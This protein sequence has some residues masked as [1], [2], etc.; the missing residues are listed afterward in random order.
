M[1]S[2]TRVSGHAACVKDSRKQIYL[3]LGL[4][5]RMNFGYVEGQ[6]ENT[7]NQGEKTTWY[8][9]K[10]SF[11]LALCKKLPKLCSTWFYLGHS[12]KRYT[13]PEDCKSPIVSSFSFNGWDSLFQVNTTFDEQVKGN[14]ATFY[15]KYPVSGLE[16]P[17]LDE[18]EQSQLPFY[19]PPPTSACTGGGLSPVMSPTSTQT[20][21]VATAG[22]IWFAIT[23][24]V[25][26]VFL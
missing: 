19:E 5:G 24:G 13:L 15:E 9:G 25:F 1:A 6:F 26:M 3:T 12:G 11:R 2:I 7:G 16:L 10:S 21:G 22:G 8:L 17:P 4:L 18:L 23:V 14:F 20:S